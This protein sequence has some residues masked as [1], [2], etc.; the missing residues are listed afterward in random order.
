MKSRIQSINPISI[1]REKP[2]LAGPAFLLYV[3]AQK[4][5]NLRPAGYESD[6]LTPELWARTLSTNVIKPTKSSYEKE[7]NLE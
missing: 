5:L 1:K 6:A 4:D 2:A 7:N 3:W